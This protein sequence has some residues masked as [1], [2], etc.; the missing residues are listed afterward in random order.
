VVLDPGGSAWAGEMIVQAVKSLTKDPVVAIFNS[1]AHGD[2]W[3]GNEGIKRHY[4][5]VL[6]Y[7]HPIMKT[8]LEGTDGPYWLE[9]IERVTKGSA[10]G[11]MVIAPERTV[12]DGDLVEIGDTQFRIYHRGPAHTDNDIMIEI[13]G[14]GTLFTGDV[15][16]NGHLGVMESD[17]SFAGNIATIDA[18]VG[19]KF[20]HYIPGHGLAGGK[21]IALVY[22]TYFDTLLTT[23]R[24][25]YADDIPDYEMKPAVVEAV[26][27]FSDW[28]GFDM[29]VGPHVSRAYLE[30]EED[31]F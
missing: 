21:E 7:G 15:V 5:Q 1:H 3:L 30:V 27:A 23:V 9:L 28:A 4:P 10:G 19:K 14:A 11:K 8:R 29:W 2:H 22:R 20:R 24:K 31:N 26:S 6:I 13:V 12:N 17:A 25:L 16:R 18:I